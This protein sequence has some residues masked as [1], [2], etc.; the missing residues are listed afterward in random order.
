MSILCEIMK[1]CGSD[2][3]LGWHNY[4]IYY[5][6]LFK[7]IKYNNLNIFELRSSIWMVKK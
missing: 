2:K 6:N 4:T 3:G 5:D 7:Y 1:R